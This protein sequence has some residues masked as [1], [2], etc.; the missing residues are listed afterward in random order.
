MFWG[1]KGKILNTAL[2]LED[3][4]YLIFCHFQQESIFK[5]N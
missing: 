1:E 2:F 3:K 4:S 5:L